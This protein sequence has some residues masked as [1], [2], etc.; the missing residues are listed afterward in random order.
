MI[1]SME[2]EVT[3][4]DPAGLVT[5]SCFAG[6]G[7]GVWIGDDFEARIGQ[8][9][10]AE[11]DVFEGRVRP[12]SGVGVRLD[13][14]SVV[15]SGQWQL[16]ARDDTFLRLAECLMWVK[17]LDGATADDFAAVEVVAE[18]SAVQVTPYLLIEP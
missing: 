2:I 3:G 12:G 18:R 1:G 7:A 6:E 9:Y 13:G 8:G 16:T 5:F 4:V 10:H 17:L 14:T 15:F 11:L